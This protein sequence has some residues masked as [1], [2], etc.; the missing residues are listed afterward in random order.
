MNSPFAALLRYLASRIRPLNLFV[1]AAI[2][3]VL[4]VTVGGTYL[5][6]GK[7]G[8]NYLATAI[9]SATL[10]AILGLGWPNLKRALLRARSPVEVGEYL[11]LAGEAFPFKV[12]DGPATYQPPELVL[13]TTG[14]LVLP[15]ILRQ[16][17]DHMVERMKTYTGEHVLFDGQCFVMVGP[18]MIRRSWET[19]RERPTV[20]VELKK[21]T[22]YIRVLCRGAMAQELEDHISVDWPLSVPSIKNLR[23]EL[24]TQN[25][26]FSP[27]LHP[28]AGI[29]LCLVAYDR[30]G[31][32]WTI[33]QRR[34]VGIAENTGTWAAS[35]HESFSLDDVTAEG[36]IDAFSTAA[37]GAREELGISLTKIEYFVVGIDEGSLPG[38]RITRSGGF[39]LVGFAETSLAAERLE[40]TR[41]RGRDKFESAEIFAVQLS[42]ESVLGVLIKAPPRQWF[43]PALLAL[44]E[45]LE[46]FRPGSWHRIASELETRR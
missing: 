25:D 3:V 43:T 10:G 11:V 24:V 20:I 31:R 28:G 5:I 41:F 13:N 17:Y 2:L 8:G 23:R 42:V 40:D 14:E 46:R 30:T 27:F 7:T 4:T 1:V 6:L 37:R 44:L 22:Y 29:N 15:D 45:T 19:V 36:T 35:I 33:V 34:G 9:F 38:A 12:L 18:P 21:T 39:E 26:D 16:A 32:P